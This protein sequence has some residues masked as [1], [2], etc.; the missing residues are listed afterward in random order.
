M[1]F[2]Q[3]EGSAKPAKQS[4]GAVSL[5]IRVPKSEVGEQVGCK[6]GPRW[7]DEEPRGPMMRPE[8]LKHVLRWPQKGSQTYDPCENPKIGNRFWGHF[9]AILGSSWGLL[10]CYGGVWGGLWLE[11]CGL[12]RLSCSSKLQKSRIVKLAKKPLEKQ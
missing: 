7:A 9:G 10:G 3:R 2:R 11:C 8:W 6:R 4:L 5:G 1:G 12:V